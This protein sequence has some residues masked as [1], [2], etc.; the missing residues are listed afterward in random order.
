MRR[1]SALPDKEKIAALYAYAQR[2]FTVCGVQVQDDEA[3]A[4]YDEAL[5]SDHTM[6]AQHVQTMQ[7]FADDAVVKCKRAD[8]GLRRIKHVLWDCI[9]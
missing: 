3:A 5:F 7:A 9:Y 6:T 8:G 1:L 2:I 4:L